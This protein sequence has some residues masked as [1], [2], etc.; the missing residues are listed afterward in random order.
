M[1][2]EIREVNSRK[3]RRQFIHLPAKI[4]KDHKNW[5][6]PIYMDDRSFF[7]PRINKSFAYSDTLILLAFRDKFPVGRIMGIIN[8]RHNE[9]KGE[10]H[11]RFCFMECWNDQ[12][13]SD[14][15]LSSVEKWAVDLALRK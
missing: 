1:A 14:A 3:L 10:K 15:L 12:E 6:P 5:V 4:H 8:H 13:V 2:I 11:A 7:N 9:L